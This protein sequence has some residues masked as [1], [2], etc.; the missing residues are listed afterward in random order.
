MQE[1]PPVLDTT[2]LEL[3]KI[4]IDSKAEIGRRTE[5]LGQKP[6]SHRSQ[7]LIK[8]HL[9]GVSSNERDDDEKNG[10]KMV[11]IRQRPPKHEIMTASI[12]DGGCS[13]LVNSVY[14]GG[15]PMGIA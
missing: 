9:L 10:K 2:L 3:T 4:C 7:S 12:E 14:N 8:S 15:G 13:S 1:S 11:V 6:E 5:I